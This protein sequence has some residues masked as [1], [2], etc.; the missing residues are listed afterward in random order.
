MYWLCS[1]WFVKYYRLWF[2]LNEMCDLNSSITWQNCKMSLIIIKSINL[3]LIIEPAKVTESDLENI[4]C[5]HVFSMWLI[6]IIYI[7]II[8]SHISLHFRNINEQKLSL[9]RNLFEM[10]IKVM[11]ITIPKQKHEH[12]KPSLRSPELENKLFDKNVEKRNRI[13]KQST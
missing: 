1:Y 5:R 3:E 6:K 11:T 7:H 2:L 9:W 13:H 12:N 10:M 4:R 8:Q